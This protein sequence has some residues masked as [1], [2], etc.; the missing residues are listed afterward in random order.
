MKSLFFIALLSLGYA[1]IAAGQSR[2][3]VWNDEFDYEGEP[4]PAK[5][6]YELGDGCPAICGWGNNER[7][8]YT[9]NENNVRVAD[10]KLIIEVHQ[11][12]GEAYE[13]SSSKVVSTG[14]GDWKYG[15][16]EVRAKLPYGKGTWPAIWML[17]TLDRN[18][19]WPMDGEIDIMEHVG[20]NLGTVYGTIHTGKYNHRIGTH[21]SDSLE[22]ARV[23]QEFHVYAIDWG[24]EYISWSIDGNEFYTVNKNGDGRDGWPFDQD[25]HLILNVAVGGDWGGKYGIDISVWPQRMEIDYVRVYKNE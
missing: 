7:Q 1:E 4:D 24:P 5:W 15:Y 3:L 8:Y 20:Y 16:I 11:E 9:D 2:Q 10:G 17:P 23:H 21:K 14:K 13:Y 6:G 22:V 12:E 19:D 25:F 18:L